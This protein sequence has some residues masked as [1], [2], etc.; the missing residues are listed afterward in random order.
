MIVSVPGSRYPVSPESL[1]IGRQTAGTGTADEQIAPVVIVQGSQCRRLLPCET[2]DTFVRRERIILCGR[3]RQG[4]TVIKRTVGSDMLG[5]LRVENGEWR[6]SRGGER[7]EETVAD[8]RIALAG[9]VGT[10]GSIGGS[11]REYQPSFLPVLQADAFLG[12]D[13]SFSTVR[14]KLHGYT[15]FHSFQTGLTTFQRTFHQKGV[16]PDS[17]RA[18]FRTAQ[19]GRE[20]QSP[21]TSGSQM[22]QHDITVTGNKILTTVIDIFQPESR[23]SHRIAQTEPT[24]VVV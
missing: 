14:Y 18:M 21:F 9:E 19:A 3:K 13:C 2:E 16:S 20:V 10:C 23:I 24:A 11:S 1:Q 6:M 5:E 4:N 12:A 15:V 17:H 8:F 22:N 7:T